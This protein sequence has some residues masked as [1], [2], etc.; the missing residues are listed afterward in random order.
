MADYLPYATAILAGPAY[1]LVAATRATLW[2]YPTRSRMDAD[3]VRLRPFGQVTELQIAA[4]RHHYVAALQ[5]AFFQS[6]GVTLALMAPA[7]ILAAATHSPSPESMM[8]L[9][10]QGAAIAAVA[11]SVFAFQRPTARWTRS[12]MRAETLRLHTHICLAGLRPYDNAATAPIA[13]E[14][15]RTVGQATTTDLK[16]EIRR[17]IAGLEQSAANPPGPPVDLARA[18]AYERE[19]IDE[20][21][22]YFERT[23]GVVGNL[24]RYTRTAFIAMLG[25]ALL[26]SGVRILIKYLGWDGIE[27]ATLALEV[28]V[29]L[30]TLSLTVRAIFGWE[31]RLGIY[32]PMLDER[33]KWLEE[34]K[35]LRSSSWG[36]TS[37]PIW[38]LR[39]KQLTVAIELAMAREAL[40][41]LK[42]VEKEIYE[43]PI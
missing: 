24:L 21:E 37:D 2:L 16:N 14:T 20:Q 36:N 11:L 41:W 7:H 19:R 33:T 28:A 26:A 18:D 25:I 29:A 17:V 34:R 1:G 23:V 15:T 30:I 6:I 39:F 3:R 27:T 12:R 4:N 22:R 42:V 32:E 40:E 38:Q 13:T 10:L 31:S 43:A 8:E 35:E 5:K 9:V